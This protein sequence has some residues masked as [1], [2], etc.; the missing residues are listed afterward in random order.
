MPLGI[1]CLLAGSA[2]D[3]DRF[4]SALDAINAERR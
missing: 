2:Q 3:G 1:E 4:A